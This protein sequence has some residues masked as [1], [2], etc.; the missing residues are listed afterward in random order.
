VT[1]VNN[2][3]E[4]LDLVNEHD[5]VIGKLPRGEVYAQGLSNF[6]SVNGF[7]RNRNNQLWIP[8][9]TEHKSIFPGGLDMGVAGHVES[10]E[11][12]LDSFLRECREEI[13]V[14]LNSQQFRVFGYLN[15]YLATISSFMMVYEVWLDE[16]PQ[17]N[18]DDFQSY[19]WLT[20][21]E[22]RVVVEREIVPPK[23]DL[24]TLLKI[25]YPDA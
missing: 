8:R 11:S 20:P 7:I 1:T 24:L 17:Y 3:N 25:F 23:G 10:G 9:R 19:Q 22:A 13:N 5:Q 2:T 21:R 6:R 16:T 15:P 14:S 4:L 18:V 12:Y